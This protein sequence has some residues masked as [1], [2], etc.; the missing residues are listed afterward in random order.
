MRWVFALAIVLICSQ[1]NAQGYG[2]IAGTGAGSGGSGGT[3][4]GSNTQVQY[5]A[6]SSFGG[7]SGATSNGT[8]I[9]FAAGDLLAGT[10]ALG[11][12]SLT[13]GTSPDA[14]IFSAN[15]GNVDFGANG[16]FIFR[17]SNGAG[18]TIEPGTALNWSN[19]GGNP[20][21][22]KDTGLSRAS[23]GVVDVGNGTQGDASGTLNGTAYQIGGTTVLSGTTLGSTIVTSSLTSVGALAS[24]SIGSGF[25]SINA[26]PI[27]GT[28]AAAITGTTITATS[29]LKTS[30]T[31]DSSSTTTG[32][33]QSA[34]GLG[35][36]KNLQV[37]DNI[38]IPFSTASTLGQI[39]WTNTPAPL[40]VTGNTNYPS[41]FWAGGNTSE[42]GHYNVAIGSNAG[43][44][45][46]SGANNLFVGGDAGRVVTQGTDNV[47]IGTDALFTDTTGVANLAIGTSALESLGT[48]SNNI[49]IG[50]NAGSSYTGTEGYNIII[51]ST[52]GTPGES[53]TIQFN[54]GPEDQLMLDFNHTTA[55]TWTVG[56]YDGAGIWDFANTSDTSSGSTGSL[57]TA[58]GIGITKSLWVGTTVTIG[59]LNTGTGSFLCGTA[60]SAVT[61]EATTCVASA[62]WT[63]NPE[64]W[65]DPN[66]GDKLDMLHP[67][68]YTYKDP[69]K[70]GEG[71]K[72]GIYADDVAKMD[73][74]CVT[75]DKGVLQNYDDHC[76]LAYLLVDRAKLKAQLADAAARISALEA[77]SAVTKAGLQ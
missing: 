2:V 1:A 36:A 25:T 27:G 37:G 47:A 70:N 71:E 73:S 62:L 72:V 46:T 33:L 15:A 14:G 60:G 8:S 65:L 13:I 69:K 48:G 29:T 67:A 18:V 12:Y 23:A 20:A 3:P 30:A 21:A 64:G 53:G 40:F 58:G 41:L 26:V 35:I 9:T 17:V 61:I 43:G 77:R 49:A 66:A 5:N 51:G 50:N 56:T 34:G 4:G 63:K 7:V 32:A 28:T 76:I 22:T 74:R 59:T 39:N 44:S 31:T 38:T 19:T 57:Y 10:G 52:G 45:L 11:D 16:A 55:N 54:G 75:Y 6:S 24:G 42:T 68:I